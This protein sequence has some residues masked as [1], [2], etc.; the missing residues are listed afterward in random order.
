[1]TIKIRWTLACAL[2]LPPLAH[3]SVDLNSFQ[4]HALDQS[5]YFAPPTP[6][7]SSSGQGAKGVQDVPPPLPSA[8]PGADATGFVSAPTPPS[9]PAD[10]SSKSVRKPATPL[11][12]PLPAS[13]V[14]S[15]ARISASAPSLSYTAPT[16][17]LPDMSLAAIR[18]FAHLAPSHQVVL[19]P[20]A[21]GNIALRVSGY[22]PNMLVTPFHHPVAV[23]TALAK[24][25]HLFTS[26]PYGSRLIFTLSPHYPVGVIVTGRNPADP[27]YT[28]TLV[29]KDIPGRTYVL[30]IP[31]WHP[32]PPVSAE[33]STSQRDRGLT[34][35]MVAAAE[36]RVPSGFSRSSRLPAVRFF[37]DTRLTPIA[38]YTSL[39]YAL[40]EYTVTNL[41]PHQ[42]RL[43]PAQL[44][45][46]GVLAVAFYPSNRMYGHGQ[47]RL[48]LITHRA[49]NQGNFIGF[50]GRGD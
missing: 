20:T 44:Y 35:I 13:A 1:M 27:A 43:D 46:R 36:Q 45:R 19:S 29:P 25:H 18:K 49:P 47:T 33:V 3:A 37:E 22:A 28:F 16:P 26:S 31:H 8:V 50:I 12:P 2:A 11:P 14:A 41:S 40:T 32:T 39:R 23:S 48:F 6:P 9:A 38:R 34:D 15:N 30:H 10:R 5:G 42:V 4:A 17:T 7:S 24:Q 21:T